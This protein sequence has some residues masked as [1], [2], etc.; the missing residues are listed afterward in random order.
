MNY[1]VNPKSGYGQF[2]KWNR[3]VS[4]IRIVIIPTECG[5]SD[6]PSIMVI[7]Y[8]PQHDVEYAIWR[9]ACFCSR[10]RHGP[11]LDAVDVT[12]D[13]YPGDCC[14]IQDPVVRVG[15]LTNQ[16]R[17]RKFNTTRPCHHRK[18]HYQP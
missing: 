4:Q 14:G 1:Y 13:I 18:R 15:L 10:E 17:R 12:L 3:A 11:H 6:F 7:S 5:H 16:R 2:D 8:S 9:R